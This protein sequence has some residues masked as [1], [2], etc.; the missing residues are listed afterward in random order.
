[1]LNVKNLTIAPLLREVNFRVPAGE[2]L[3]LMGPSGSGKSTLFAWM[4][5]ALSTD[6]KAHGELWLND[7]RC[8]L[9]PVETRGIGIL[10][11]DALLFDAFSVGQNLML[12]LPAHIAGRAR[13]DAV[14]QALESANPLRQR[15]GDPFRRRA[16]PG[17]PAARP[18]R[19]AAGIAAR[20]TVQPTG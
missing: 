5:G 10:F 19:P 9:L 18:S 13:R 16:R 1:M 6:F 17:Q 3:T 4:V 8:D 11:Q 7:R 20:R 12:A 2:I 14:E 15:S